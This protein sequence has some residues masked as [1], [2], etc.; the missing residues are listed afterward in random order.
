MSISIEIVDEVLGLSSVNPTEQQEHRWM[1][2]F[3]DETVTAQEIIRRRIYQE[4]QD[5]NLEPNDLF[6]N[7]FRGLVQPTNTETSLNGF[8]LKEKRQLDWEA[9]YA[10]ALEAFRNNGFIMLINDKQVES[11]EEVVELKIGTQINFLRL[12]PLVGG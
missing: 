11:L 10:K 12:I 9:Q 1:L 4:V 5:Y 2:E 3:L 6:P 8:K 7:I